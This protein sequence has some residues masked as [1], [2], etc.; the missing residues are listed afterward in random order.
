MVIPMIVSPFADYVMPGSQSFEQPGQ[1]ERATDERIS[2]E[3]MQRRPRQAV[4]RG[5]RLAEEYAYYRPV[6]SN[7]AFVCIHDPERIS[8]GLGQRQLERP[9][10]WWWWRDAGWYNRSRNA[11]GRRMAVAG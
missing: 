6:D 2:L 11:R 1:L 4:G 5:S 9:C 7:S 10:T 3:H 8:E